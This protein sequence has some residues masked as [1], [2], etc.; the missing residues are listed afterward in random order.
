VR[1]RKVEATFT[2]KGGPKGRMNVVALT[3]TAMLMGAPLG[4]QANSNTTRDNDRLVQHKQRANK[5][6]HLLLREDVRY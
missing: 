3:G 2:S 1:N 5:R 4:G 6:K